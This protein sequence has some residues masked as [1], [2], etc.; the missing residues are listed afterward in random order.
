MKVSHAINICLAVVLVVV[1]LVGFVHIQEKNKTINQLTT[2]LK[3]STLKYPTASDIANLAVEYSKE[4]KEGLRSDV[5]TQKF[6]SFALKRGFHAGA[7]AVGF[8]RATYY[9]TYF[10][11]ID[12]KGHKKEVFLNSYDTKFLNL[13]LGTH[14]SEENGH[15]LLTDESGNVV[16]DKITAISKLF[17]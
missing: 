16:D 5:A 6:L 4:T 2:D 17:W 14:F 15:G 11:V 3:N 1:A 13:K 12:E 8:A 7:V 9:A 10:I